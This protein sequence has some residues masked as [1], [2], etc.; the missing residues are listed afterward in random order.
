MKIPFYSSAK[1]RDLNQPAPAEVP[2]LRSSSLAA[3]YRAARVGGDFYDFVVTPAGRLVFIVT[4]I[5]GRREEAFHVAA[6]A[7]RVFRERVE[8]NFSG[9]IFN[10]HDAMTDLLIE[11]NRAI[12]TA[13]GG[14]RNAPSFIG[15]YEEHLGTLSYINA[16]HPPALLKDSTGIT[17]L[18]ANGF[19]L[20]LFSHAAHDT[21]LSV[22][23]PGAALLIVSK[24]L[25][26][27]RH[28][29]KEFG[30]ERLTEIFS[31]AVFHDAHELCSGIL[32]SVDQFMNS[33][34]KPRV[35]ENDITAVALVRAA[36]GDSATA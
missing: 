16:G 13:A 18:P 24:G 10:E 35:A 25:V 31:T 30:M 9:E 1:K 26:E 29:H 19:P 7:Q 3:L 12:I 20:G 32:D 2:K 28:R 22:L 11:V 5:A 4:D 17:Q 14:V 34:R 21:Q 6:A 23:Q 8:Q 36:A 15:C 33:G 27:S